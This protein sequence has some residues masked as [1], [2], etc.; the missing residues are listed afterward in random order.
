LEKWPRVL[1]DQHDLKPT[2]VHTSQF[3]LVILLLLPPPR[4]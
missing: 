1:D 4:R 3:A 2:P